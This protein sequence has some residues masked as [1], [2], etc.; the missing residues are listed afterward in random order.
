MSLKRDGAPDVTEVTVMGLQALA[1]GEC[2]LT[3]RMSG[4]G[5]INVRAARAFE[6]QGWCTVHDSL[7][8]VRVKITP[9]GLQTLAA[10]L[11]HRERRL[12]RTNPIGPRSKQQPLGALCQHCHYRPA[13][14]NKKYPWLATNY[15]SLHCRQAASHAR[16]DLLAGALA[17]EIREMLGMPANK[18]RNFTN[19]EMR[20][21]RAR[22]ELLGVKRLS[23]KKR[24]D[25]GIKQPSRRKVS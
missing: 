1:D 13:L 22:L 25:A 16:S 11:D 15:C 20:A 23:R 14:P 21:M 17:N 7:L 19:P 4:G 18:G 8:G 3:N 12:A 10:A 2:E 9:A 24:K 5:Y 6:R